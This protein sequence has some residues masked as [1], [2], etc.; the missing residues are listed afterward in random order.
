MKSRVHSPP[1]TTSHRHLGQT[2]FRGD[3]V[4]TWAKTATWM[5]VA[6]VIPS[7]M[8][9][10]QYSFRALLEG[11]PCFNAS[12]TSLGEIVYVVALLPAVQLGTA[13]LTFG[14]IRPWGE[15]FP[16]WVPLMGGRR[17]PTSL[18]VGA[19]LTATAAITAF[20]TFSWLISDNEPT[21]DLPADCVLPGGE[22]DIYYSPMILWPALVLAVTGHYWRRRAIAQ[23]RVLSANHH[24]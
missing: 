24:R 9:R 6:T 18:G 10:V 8:W 16:A 12:A 7:V 20:V 2:P 1:T 15:Q 13:S 23:W 17:V 5:A 11:D 19:A 14:L 21:R 22:I 4:P 3:L